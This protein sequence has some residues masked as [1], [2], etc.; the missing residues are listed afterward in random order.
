MKHRL[1]PG[2]LVTAAIAA[3]LAACSSG[4]RDGHDSQSVDFEADA[5]YPGPCESLTTHVDGSTS[6]HHLFGYDEEGWLVLDELDLEP[7]GVFDYATS[8]QRDG[9]G[10][11]LVMG[12]DV[13]MDGIADSVYHYA[14]DDQGNLL[15]WEYDED[16]DGSYD[17]SISYGYDEHGNRILEQSGDVTHR[18]TNSY[19]DDGL[20]VTVEYDAEDDGTVERTTHYTYV[21]DAAGGLLERRLE[22]TD[23]SSGVESWSTVVERYDGAGILLESETNGSSSESEG[24]WSRHE[25]YDEAGRLLES[26]YWNDGSVFAELELRSYDGFG[27]HLETAVLQGHCDPEAVPD[28]VVE[29]RYECWD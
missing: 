7:D 19:D 6:N 12:H 10:R 3:L 28:Y 4:D 26:C 5:L 29:Y 22:S 16:G 17:R 21:H 14:Y 23:T 15:L 25:L 24:A 11:V 1:G 27:N 20:L 13:D 9:E 2:R 8:Y 18:Y